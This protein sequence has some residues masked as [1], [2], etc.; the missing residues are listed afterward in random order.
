MIQQFAG[1][2][3]GGTTMKSL[4]V[5]EAGKMTQ[6]PTIATGKNAAK[7]LA[8]LALEL[9]KDNPNIRGIGIVSPGIVDAES[10]VVQYTANLDLQGE[11]IVQIVQEL[12]G[13]PTLLSHDGRAGG[14]AEA[15]LGAGR[16]TD[17]FVMVPIGT[18]ISAA[19]FTGGSVIAGATYSAG[20]IGHIPVFPD[21]TPCSCGQR[22]CMEVYASASAIARRYGELSGKQATALE[23]EQLL[24]KDLHADQTWHEA[25]QALALGLT[26]VTLIL[27]PE[28]II[29]GGGLSGAG[30]K[31][32]T[33][34]HA[35]MKQMMA[36]RTPPRLE[37][38]Q[39]GENAGK[40]G[41][42]ILGAM[43]AGSTSFESWSLDG[44]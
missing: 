38:S 39:L 7:M 34:L 41:A 35:S 5:D 6:G 27:D 4:V 13:V 43:A 21:G 10:G 18:G 16:G 26:H 33:P 2:D 11:P 9:A 42:A 1:I 3:V 30:E 25:V 37:V 14:M 36:W 40:W 12:T 44:K 31:L 22:G 28:L 8:Q 15:T 32:L 17:N 19:L 24:G 29:I 23:V 20:E